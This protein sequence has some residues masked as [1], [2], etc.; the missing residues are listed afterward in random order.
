MTPS[1]MWR[2]WARVRA[3]ATRLRYRPGN[4]SEQDV[5][6]DQHQARSRAVGGVNRSQEGDAHGTTSST[7]ND[8]FVGRVTGQDAGYAGET[9][10]ERRS[11]VTGP[12]DEH[13]SEIDEHRSAR[14]QDR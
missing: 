6:S 2:G 13:G 12:T 8:L 5:E 1:T 14:E 4:R 11:G 9:G 10:A 3:W 7:G